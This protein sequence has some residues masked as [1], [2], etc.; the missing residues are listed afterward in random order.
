MD[1]GRNQGAES[2][3]CTARKILHSCQCWVQA[4][5]EGVLRE[6]RGWNKGGTEGKPVLAIVSAHGRAAEFV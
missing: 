5:A 4:L 1:V 2:Y 6:G 3:T